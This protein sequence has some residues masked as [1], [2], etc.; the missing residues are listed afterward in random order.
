MDNSL[1]TEH[2]LQTDHTKS[3]CLV[4]MQL[5]ATM[6]HMKQHL[7]SRGAMLWLH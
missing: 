4:P 6:T 7:G 1:L 3:L 2:V 5:C